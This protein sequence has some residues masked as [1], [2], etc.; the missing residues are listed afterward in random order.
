MRIGIISD[1][2]ANLEALE[3]VLQDIKLRKIDG[4]WCLGDIVGYG[5]NPNECI[6]IVRSNNITC[7]MG[8]H[9]HLISGV[10][11]SDDFYLYADEHISWTRSVVT[12]EN[13]AYIHNL[14]IK[15][16]LEKVT[17]VHG[18]PKQPFDY[19]ISM[20]EAEE[21]IPYLKTPLCFMGHSHI[22][23]VA[24]FKDYKH[25]KLRY[26]KNRGRIVLS[27]SIEFINPG[28]VGQPRDENPESSYMIYDTETNS[29]LNR[30]I[31]Y[32]V[33]KARKK[34]IDAGLPVWLGDRL[35]VGR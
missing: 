13:L 5:A 35:L 21:A 17:L 22:P 4:I 6:D 12:K 31:K 16:E 25:K 19:I 30:R 28:S 27:N 34:I 33:C 7:V 3:A 24:T 20:F 14:P 10:D 32:D 18:S 2:H 1:I 23:M 9:E 29:V 26:V 8:N 11:V 15:I